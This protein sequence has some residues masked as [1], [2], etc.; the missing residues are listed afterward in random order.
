VTELA[1]ELAQV[2]QTWD[3]MDVDKVRAVSWVSPPQVA[4][5]V[6]FGFAPGEGPVRLVRRLLAENRPPSRELTGGALVCGDMA[7]ESAFFEFD[8]GSSFADV[9][10]WDLSQD[11]LDRFRPRLGLRW[12]PHKIDCN[13]LQLEAGEFDLLVASHGAHHVANLGNL[14]SQAHRGLRPGGLLFMHEWIGPPYLQLPR[15][16]RLVATALLLTLFP[17]R[18]T[19]T[20]HMGRVKGIRYLQDPPDSFDP[21]EA[22]NSLE[23][24]PQFLEHFD[25]L[26]E[27]LHGGLTYPMF[28][29]LAPNLAVDQP[30]TRRR[31]ALVLRIERWMTRR[32]L[33]HPLF[34][35]VVG[36]RKDDVSSADALP[37][38]DS[39][40]RDTASPPVP[41]GDGQLRSRMDEMAAH[42]RSEPSP[43]LEREL[44]PVRHAAFFDGPRPDGQPDWPP[45]VTQ[46]LAT[47]QSGIPEI[48]RHDL[49]V[50]VLRAAVLGRGSLIVRGLLDDDAVSR[51][52]DAT[53]R[54]MAAYDE[55]Q[56]TSGDRAAE[57]R[58]WHEPFVSLPGHVSVTDA[59]RMW[60]RSGGGVFLAESPRTLALV[61]ESLEAVGVLEVLRQ[62]FGERP[63]LSVKKGT[64][65]VVPPD[66]SAGWHQDGAF[67]GTDVRAMNVWVA[68]S[69]CGVDAPSLDVVA[70][71]LDEL[72][73]TGV[74][75]ADFDWSV[76]DRA[77]E[78]AAGE[79]GIASPVFAAG[80][81]ILFDQMNLHRTGARPGLTKDRLAIEAWFFAP[82]HYP[83]DQVPLLV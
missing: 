59:D 65:R 4:D 44:V 30:R 56:D 7:S 22:C 54:A 24:R 27:H 39:D 21:S 74:D 70:R 16:N 12:H 81:A 64:L 51:L 29:G 68:L 11:S 75:G 79:H 1:G 62:H 52:A 40:E 15:R 14:F 28:E 69:P 63:A 76:S 49:S 9:H 37:V 42:N 2:E 71:R 10:G 8:D 41:T 3:A 53:R 23:L 47:E 17:R 36:R 20:T 32:G 61:I 18:A 25:V 33:V 34:T 13:D 48:G 60:V 55:A 66:T 19:R 31:L 43:E 77:A 26:A 46:R 73:T 35:M 82:S 78:A 5:D 6:N 80:D 57:Q 50:E 72:V 45:A 83:L 67:L 58:A 38:A